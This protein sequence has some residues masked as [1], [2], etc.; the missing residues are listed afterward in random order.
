[1]NENEMRLLGIIRESDDPEKAML[2]AVEVI[3]DF[4]RQLLSSEAPAAACPPGLSGTI[5]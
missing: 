3:T 5:L 4:L 2:V 1:M